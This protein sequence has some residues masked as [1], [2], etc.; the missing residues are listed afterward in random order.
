VV[1]LVAGAAVWRRKNILTG[2]KTMPTEETLREFAAQLAGCQRTSP[3]L[4]DMQQLIVKMKDNKAN[5]RTELDR[6]QA[7][8]I[9]EME[10]LYAYYKTF[11]VDRV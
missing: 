4:E 11:V 5:D 1:D 8:A 3:I 7:I 2:E 10:K 9:T 6:R